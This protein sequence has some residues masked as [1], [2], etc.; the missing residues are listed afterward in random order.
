MLQRDMDVDILI[1]GHTHKYEAFEA[2]DKFFINPGSATGA[3]SG[4]TRHEKK[5]TK[6]LNIFINFHFIILVMFV[7]VL[8][9]WMFKEI[10][11]LFILT[12]SEM[13]MLK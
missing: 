5:N 1:S 7:Q 8:Y 11:L 12:N 9:L 10:M 4:F 6:R 2:N 3:Y 13:E